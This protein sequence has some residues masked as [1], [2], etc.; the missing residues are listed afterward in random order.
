MASEAKSGAE[1]ASRGSHSARD[2]SSGYG[3][4]R[5]QKQPCHDEDGPGDLSNALTGRCETLD[6]NR[7]RHYRHRSKVHDA[8]Y[9]EDRNQTDTAAAAVEAEAHAVPPSRTGIGRQRMAAPG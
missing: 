3:C 4:T 7:C 5:D 6:S 8:E 9:Q 2:T 1:M